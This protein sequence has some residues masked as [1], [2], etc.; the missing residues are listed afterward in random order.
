MQ[1][2]LGFVKDIRAGTIRLRDYPDERLEIV[3]QEGTG[4][5]MFRIDHLNP[6]TL[7]NYPTLPRGVLQ[8]QWQRDVV[9][10]RKTN[11][12]GKSKKG[13]QG[14]IATAMMGW[15]DEN[16]NEKDKELE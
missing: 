1:A 6:Y 5:F 15:N 2:K 13:K 10:E 16:W 8:H 9:I 12:E 14:K 11:A 4:L 7:L 3:W